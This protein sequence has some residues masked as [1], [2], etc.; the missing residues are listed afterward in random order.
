MLTKEHGHGRFCWYDCVVPDTAVVVKF[1]SALFGWTAKT[2]DMGPA[3]P[4]TIFSAGGVDFAGV[5]KPPMPGVPPHWLAYVGVPDADAACI[6]VRANGGTVHVPPTNIPNVGRFAVIAD[7]TGGSIAPFQPAGPPMRDLNAP[8]VVGLVGWNELVTPE[9]A[10]AGAFY[11]RLFGWMMSPMPMPDGTTYQIFKRG[12]ND[13]AGM[14]KTPPNVPPGPG[15][16]LIYIHVADADATTKKAEGLGARVLMA[17]WTV[18]TVGRLAVL[19]DPS[20][21]VFALH[22]VEKKP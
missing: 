13:V 21:A 1:Y 7:P 8:P 16:W 10:K 4:Y 19:A 9:P 14:M 3:G 5:M 11:T 2:M 12:G 17:P 22:Q 15:R 18:P 6:T 20:G